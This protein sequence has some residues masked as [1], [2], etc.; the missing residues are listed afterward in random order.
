MKVLVV[1]DESKLTSLI[2]KGLRCEGIEVE[3]T[4]SGL[5]ALDQVKR[6]SYD[7]VVLDIMIHEL[8]GLSVLKRMRAASIRTPVIIITARDMH[9]EK[10]EGLDAGAD[11]YVVKPFFVDELV[12]RLNAVWRRSLGQGLDVLSVDDLT[13]NLMTRE[14]TRGGVKIDMPTKEFNLLVFL[15][16]APGRVFNRVQIFENVWN[17]DFDPETN[18]VDVYIGRLRRKIDQ[19]DS[20]KLLE[21]VRGVGYRIRRSDDS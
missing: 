3:S 2:E 19:G 11:D 1:E 4:S 21:T 16:K 17:F 10:I 13:V 9:N 14:V 15:M 7:A 8:D 18:L 6:F 20:K 5:E 12:A